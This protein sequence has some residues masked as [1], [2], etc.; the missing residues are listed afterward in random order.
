MQPGSLRFGT[1]LDHRYQRVQ[2]EVVL[3]DGAR[4]PGLPSVL[5]GEEVAVGAHREARALV[6]KPDVEQGKL[7]LRRLVHHRP[8]LAAIDGAQDH[9]VVSHRPAGAFV[10]HVYRGEQNAGRHLGLLPACVPPSVDTRTCPRSPTTTTREPTAA[11]SSSSD[12]IASGALTAAAPC[13]PAGAREPQQEDEHHST[14]ARELPAGKGAGR[15]LAR[16]DRRFRAGCRRSWSAQEPGGGRF[17]CRAPMVWM[18][19]CPGPGR[20]PGSQPAGAGVIAGL[21]GAGRPG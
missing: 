2:V 12:S 21:R 16:P 13:A 6:A 7:L 20:R 17:R 18:R 19:S 1:L 14:G 15:S 10:V 4:R 5:G 11:P 3:A 8:A 9:R